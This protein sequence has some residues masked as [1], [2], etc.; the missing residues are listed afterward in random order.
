V[1]RHE[2]R[3]IS[4]FLCCREIYIIAVLQGPGKYQGGSTYSYP[5]FGEG[6]KRGKAKK[7]VYRGLKY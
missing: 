4:D 1:I 2:S 6:E 7:E 3:D 5:V